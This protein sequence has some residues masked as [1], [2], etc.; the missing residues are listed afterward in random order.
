MAIKVEPQPET[1][2]LT[3]SEEGGL[4]HPLLAALPARRERALH[5]AVLPF[6]I[7][8]RQPIPLPKLPPI[9][10]SRTLARRRRHRGRRRP[11]GRHRNLCP[12]SRSSPSGS[13]STSIGRYPQM[14]VSG[15]MSTGLFSTVHWIANLTK[16]G[17][18]TYRRRDPGIGTRPWRRSRTTASRSRRAAAGC[19]IR[20]RRPSRSADLAASSARGP[21][22][23][24]HPTSTTSTSRS[25]SRPAST[26]ATSSRHLLAPQP[27]GDAAVRDAHDRRR[28]FSARASTSRPRRA[29]SV[30]VA[31]AGRE[32]DV[33]QSGDARRD[34]GLLV[35]RCPQG[36]VGDLDLLRG[37]CTTWAHG[38]GGIMFDDIGP[39]QRQGTSIFID[40]F[41]SDPAPAGDPAPAAFIDRMRFWTGVHETGHAFNLAHAWQKSLTSG[42]KGPWLPLVDRA[43]VAVVHE[44]P[45]LR[46][47][48]QDR[49]LRRLRVPVQRPGAAVHAARAVQLRP[50]G[51]RPV[52]RPSRLPRR[53][54]AAGADLPARCPREP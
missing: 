40:S 12:T 25:T 10:A 27:T 43:R 9:P 39:Q 14:V 17:S 7:I 31:G 3:G 54:R 8:P 13:A 37:D 33:E 47:R 6:S 49:V 53:Q 34:A 52:V 42:G 11:G 41:I 23:T 4:R 22:R 18:N 51:Q 44:L 20:E 24:R 2:A 48:R 5:V 16:T 45:V 21:T 50:A 19:S 1:A 32:R 36:A 38:L 35:A 26:P 30:P 46:G 15:D 29:A 28:S